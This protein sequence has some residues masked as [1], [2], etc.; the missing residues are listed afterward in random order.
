[1]KRN[2]LKLQR[3]WDK[4]G[5]RTRKGRELAGEKQEGSSVLSPIPSSGRANGTVAAWPF[6]VILDFKNRLGPVTDDITNKVKSRSFQLL[7]HKTPTHHVPGYI[8]PLYEVSL[9]PV[10]PKY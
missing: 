5:P 6:P 8:P 4:R 7:S 3:R 9:L 10:S 1:M 2:R